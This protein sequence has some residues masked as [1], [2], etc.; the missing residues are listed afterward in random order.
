MGRLLLVRHAR[1]LRTASLPPAQWNI[2]PNGVG[3]IADLA[4][5]VRCLGLQRIRTSSEPKAVQTGSVLAQALRVPA[6]SDLRLNEV[7]RPWVGDDGAFTEMVQSYLGGGAVTGWESQEAV[8]ARMRD[9]AGDAIQAGSVVLVSHATALALFVAHLGLARAADFW[10]QLTS[11]DAWLVD[12]SMIRR[13][14]G[15]G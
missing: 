12:G 14:G 11:P 15:P 10:V 4:G 8:V 3:A 1:P 5:A 2:D 7:H 13:V 6:E 9:A